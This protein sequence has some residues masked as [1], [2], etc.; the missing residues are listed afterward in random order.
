MNEEDGCLLK[1]PAGKYVVAAQGKD[2]NGFCVVGRLRVYPKVLRADRLKTV[3]AIGE[4]GTDSAAIT[5]CD[6]RGLCRVIA[7]QKSSFLQ[8]IL[9]QAVET[10]IQTQTDDQAF[11]QPEQSAPFHTE[12][13]EL[14]AYR[15]IFC[16]GMEVP[17]PLRSYTSCNTSAAAVQ[18]AMS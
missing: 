2:F 7:G 11:I 14:L 15:A 10:A 3:R 1:L 8:E 13:A 4:T 16:T 18:S 12:D 5:V 9:A 6:L 17:A